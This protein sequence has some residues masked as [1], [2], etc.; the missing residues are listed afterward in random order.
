MASV[1]ADV[2]PSTIAGTHRDEA[3]GDTTRFRG[4]VVD[5]AA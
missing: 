2:S 4:N 1:P 3:D 5:V